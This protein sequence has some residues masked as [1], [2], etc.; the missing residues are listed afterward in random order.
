MRINRNIENLVKKKSK[1]IGM[2]K[3]KDRKVMWEGEW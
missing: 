2:I 3:E 1:E